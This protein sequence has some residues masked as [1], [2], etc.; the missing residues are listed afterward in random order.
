MMTV[1]RRLMALVVMALTA[2][3]TWA[4]DADTTFK[5]WA[6]VLS[7]EGGGGKQFSLEEKP[8]FTGLS[9][10]NTGVRVGVV[11]FG[12]LGGGP[13]RGAVEV[14]LE[15]LYQR[16]LD[17]VQADFAGLAVVG[18]YHFVS[19][20]RVVPHVELSGGKSRPATDALLPDS[21]LN[22][23]SRRTPSSGPVKVGQVHYI[24]R[25]LVSLPTSTTSIRSRATW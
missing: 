3:S 24:G 17:P 19:L 2:Q 20:G 10:L 8:G 9:F 23:R 18:R 1:H 6:W 14:G 12:I 15:P 13:F 4:G 25:H 5:Q 22:G 16:Y 7:G 21:S 11:P